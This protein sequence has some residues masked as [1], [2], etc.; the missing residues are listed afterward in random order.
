MQALAEHVER[1]I[2]RFVGSVGD[3][4]VDGFLQQFFVFGSQNDLH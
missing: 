1:L 3:A 4:G 2:E